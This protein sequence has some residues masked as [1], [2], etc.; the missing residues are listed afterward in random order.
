MFQKIIH[1]ISNFDC[2]CYS[3]F[4]SFSLFAFLI[5]TFITIYF[6]FSWF[7]LINDNFF[8]FLFWS[9]GH[10]PL[11][12]TWSTVTAYSTSASTIWIRS[13]ATA[14]ASA[15]FLWASFL[16]S[17]FCWLGIT[18]SFFCFQFLVLFLTWRRVWL[19][20]FLIWIRVIKVSL[21]DTWL[22]SFVIFRGSFSFLYI[23]E[24]LP[25]IL[26]LIHSL[27]YLISSFY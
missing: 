26:S 8:S 23:N 1:V 20:N 18:F 2:L 13:T 9:L 7:C 16:F 4:S 25:L 11:F 6:L 10:F 3:L 21:F 14:T 22:N 15:S 17:R 19:L 27:F 5:W 12:R 24:G